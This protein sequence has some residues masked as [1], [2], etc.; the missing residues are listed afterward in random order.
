MPQFVHLPQ[1]RVDASVKSDSFPDANRLLQVMDFVE[2]LQVTTLRL[3]KTM[4]VRCENTCGLPVCGCNHPAG[5]SSYP[6]RSVRGPCTVSPAF[7]LR[8]RKD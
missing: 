6:R 5:P 1:T 4:I 2:K 8:N 3:E 7:G